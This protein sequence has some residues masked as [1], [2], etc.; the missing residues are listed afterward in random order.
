[1]N[2]FSHPVI[3]GTATYV[4]DVVVDVFVGW[5]RQFLDESRGGHHES[6]LA[7]AALRD[8]LFNPCLLHGVRVFFGPETL[9]RR[10]RLSFRKFDGIRTATNRITIDQDRA[11]TARRFSSTE[12]CAL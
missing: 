3:R 11:G 12:L 10:D 2:C 4:D 5:V 6:G 1:M 7:V 9:D 8:D